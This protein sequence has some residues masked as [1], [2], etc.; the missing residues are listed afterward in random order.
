MQFVVWGGNG[1]P[2]P[3]PDGQFPDCRWTDELK[4]VWM[5]ARPPGPTQVLP[6]AAVVREAGVPTIALYPARGSSQRY[7][8]RTSPPTPSDTFLV[9]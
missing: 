2:Q 7:L 9:L 6:W 4:Q 3:G 8:V 1:L 5:S